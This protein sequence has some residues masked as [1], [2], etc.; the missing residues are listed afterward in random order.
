M[1]NNLRYTKEGNTWT[2][3]CGSGIVK[4]CA[5]E[6]KAINLIAKLKKAGF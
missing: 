1:T 3:W 4:A 2:V 6:R 5:T